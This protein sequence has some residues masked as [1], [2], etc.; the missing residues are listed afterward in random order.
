MNLLNKYYVTRDRCWTGGNSEINKIQFLCS[1]IAGS[2]GKTNTETDINNGE[3][4]ATKRRSLSLFLLSIYSKYLM[5]NYYSEPCCNLKAGY[6][7]EIKKRDMD[8]GA[9]DRMVFPCVSAW[10]AAYYD[11]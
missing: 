8:P 2:E 7:V 10:W 5:F 11:I 4:N 9:L 6:I 3:I 1:G